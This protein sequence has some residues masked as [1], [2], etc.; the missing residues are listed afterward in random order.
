MSSPGTATGTNVLLVVYSNTNTGVALSDTRTVIVLS[1]L[2]ISGLGGNNQLVLWN[3]TPGVNYE[4]LATTNL[5]QPFQPI[6]GIIPSQG[7]TTSFYDANPEPQKFYEIEM[8]Q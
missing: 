7:T 2:V 5:A 6:S 8:V 4:V 1:P 3:S